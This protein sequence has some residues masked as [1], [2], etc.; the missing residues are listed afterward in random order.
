M[1]S[2]PLSSRSL[3]PEIGWGLTLSKTKNFRLFQT[4]RV[5]RRQFRIRWEKVLQTGKKHC[6]KGEFAR[7]EQILLFPQSFRKACTAD[8]LKPRLVSERVKHL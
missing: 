3:K 1:F 5:S 2:K 7:Y 6:V 8:T 4:E